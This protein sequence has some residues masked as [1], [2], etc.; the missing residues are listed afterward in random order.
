MMRLQYL[1]S[2]HLPFM[3]LGSQ[4]RRM[5]SKPGKQ[6]SRDGAQCLL[7]DLGPV[8]LPLWAPSFTS[9]HGG[10]GVYL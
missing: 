6:E 8:S 7:C 10:V 4:E 3:Q 9:I 2:K 5:K 1:E